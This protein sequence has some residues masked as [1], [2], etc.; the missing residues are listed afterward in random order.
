MGR[1]KKRIWAVKKEDREIY[2]VSEGSKGIEIKF[3]DITWET[4]EEIENPVIIMQRVREENKSRLI[5]KG[6]KEKIEFIL[7]ELGFVVME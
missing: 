4:D 3:E 5:I 2:L 6:K 7:R 1:K